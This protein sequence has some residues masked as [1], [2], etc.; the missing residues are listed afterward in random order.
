MT[1]FLHS[2]PK[3]SCDCYQCNDDEYTFSQDGVPTNMSVRNC[4]FS[5]YYDCQPKRLFKLS[6]EPKKEV[7]KIT[8]L[9]PN[10]FLD[11]FNNPGFVT[12]N[13][14]E[15][16]NSLC[17]TEGFTSSDPRLLNAAGPSQLI[18]DRPP[19]NSTMKLNTIAH[20]TNL[21][22]YGQNYKSYHDVNAGQIIY[23]IDHSREDAFYGPNFTIPAKT[24]GIMYKDP[25]GNMLP[26]YERLVEPCDNTNNPITKEGC[27]YDNCLSWMEDSG[28]HREDLLARQ[29]RKH[30][31]QRYEPRWTN[32]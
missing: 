4:N 18:L 27:G 29:M 25:M 28:F 8:T 24:A 22:N 30:N 9:N 1:D 10:I 11:K 14:G 31:Q 23:Y 19:M 2:Y 7:Q 17:S 16:P 12:I 20:N 15:C 32:I 3:S 26:Q 6:V 13:P 5:D 21:D